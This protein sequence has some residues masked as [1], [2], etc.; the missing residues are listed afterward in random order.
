MG[1]NNLFL[2]PNQNECNLLSMP[3]SVF[4]CSQYSA[5]R[6]TV[7]TKPRFLRFFCHF[8]DSL[9]KEP[10]IKTTRRATYQSQCLS[11]THFDVRLLCLSVKNLGL[12]EM[13]AC[14][15]LLSE[16]TETAKYKIARQTVDYNGHKLTYGTFKLI[17]SVILRKRTVLN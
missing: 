13:V 8:F 11:Y 17:Q 5:M 7:S 10:D 1:K 14:V 6:A 3:C 15:T 2:F 4:P 16:K 9:T 12:V